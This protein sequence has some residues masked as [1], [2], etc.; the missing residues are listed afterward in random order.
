M[1][2]KIYALFVFLTIAGVSCKIGDD[3]DDLSSNY[4]PSV[5]VP[6]F[7]AKTNFQDVIGGKT[8]AIKI[9]PNGKMRLYYKGTVSERK[10]VD[11][12]AIFPSS[13][14]VIPYQDTIKRYP[15]KSDITLYKLFLAKKTTMAV[16]FQVP[17]G[18]PSSSI[19]GK[20][21]IPSLTK[22]GVP[23]EIN[24]SKT[25]KGNDFVIL[26][27]GLSLE[28]YILTF[29]QSNAPTEENVLTFKYTAKTSSNSQNVPLVVTIG[30]SNLG[31]NL[32][33]AFME[34][35]TLQLDPGKVDLDFFDEQEQ[36]SIKFEDPR[37]TVLVENSYGFPMRTQI[38]YI[39]SISVND[40]T[41][42]LQSQKGFDFPYPAYTTAEIGKTKYFSYDFTQKTS[43]I[44]D[45][46]NSKPKTIAYDID[47]VANPDNLTGVGFATDSTN[48][49]IGIEVDVPLTGTAKDFL[50]K[51]DFQ[52]INFAEVL[53]NIREAELKLAA[54]NAMPIEVAGVIDFLTDDGKVITST[55]TS[56]QIWVK[57]APID[58]NGKTTGIARNEITIP[59][60]E[61]KTNLLRTC[62]KI[63][64][65]FLLSTSNNGNTTVDV[66]S[67]QNVNIRMGVKA[68]TQF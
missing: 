38:N 53:T 59:F 11:A 62:K 28:N 12:L 2:I 58:A 33:E 64:V 27:Q 67:N 61:A 66:L 26:E 52:D 35:Q 40:D 39:K 8:T 46:I 49:K 13:S 31:F 3:L 24:F 14:I 50:V 25:V 57:A 47:V 55:A 45:I 29:D 41:V 34:K 9:E 37:I 17:A 54:D 44:K 7:S 60:D 56:P 10:A 65:K 22:K 42:D 5:A 16:A 4:N 18:F 43:N 19:D 23:Y 21:S 63:Q 1:K 20:I 48:L 15:F 32:M 36:G 30:I 68:K 6:L 51:Q